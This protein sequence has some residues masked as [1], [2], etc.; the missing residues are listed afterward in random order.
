[1]SDKK[2]KIEMP[3]VQG[4]TKTKLIV[5]RAH[6]A[7]KGRLPDGRVFVISINDG[8][9][10]DGASIPRALWRVCGH[11]QEI[12]RLAAALAHDW[13]YRAHVCSRETADM[14]YREI[15]RMLGIS[16][17]Q[18]CT[19]YRTLRWFGGKAWESW[20]VYDQHA[21]RSIGR[22]RWS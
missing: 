11:P 14:I 2:Y 19:E 15:S 1:M 3:I 13:L 18:Y 16:A 12:P 21:A 10:F 20:G 7:V 8:F 6:W 4:D 9:A 22:L 5:L 17:I